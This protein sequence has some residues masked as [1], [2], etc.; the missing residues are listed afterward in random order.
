MSSPIEEKSDESECADNQIDV[1]FPIQKSTLA[2]TA[3]ILQAAE[4]ENVING[5]N[6]DPPPPLIEVEDMWMFNDHMDQRK[7]TMPPELKKFC[8]ET[9]DDTK[10]GSIYYII[11][12]LY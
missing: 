7:E 5:D 12:F 8:F 3:L 10:K 11:V 2:D 4:G 1:Q 6:K 9:P